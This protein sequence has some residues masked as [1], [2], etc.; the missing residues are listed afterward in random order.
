MG[1]VLGNENKT[2]ESPNA[3]FPIFWV[4]FIEHKLNNKTFKTDPILEV[5][6]REMSSFMGTLNPKYSIYNAPYLK[7]ATRTCI[8]IPL[9][10]PSVLFTYLFARVYLRPKM[11]Y[12]CLNWRARFFSSHFMQR[13]HYV[14]RYGVCFALSS[15]ASAARLY[16][17]FFSIWFHG[18]AKNNLDRLTVAG[19][20]RPH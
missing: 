3:F 16:S 10:L 17:P 4:L 18:L 13:T 14:K 6:N 7:L 8:V 9:T 19:Q 5:L 12:A 2:A 11:S 1:A 20:T 15:L